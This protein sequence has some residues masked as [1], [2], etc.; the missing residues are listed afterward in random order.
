M[1][2]YPARTDSD[3]YF[4]MY[5]DEPE[6][7]VAFYTIAVKY[8]GLSVTA[9]FTLNSGEQRDDLVFT[10]QWAP[11][12]VRELIVFQDRTPLPR[13]ML[14]LNMYKE[15]LSTKPSAAEK[16]LKSWSIQR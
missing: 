6:F 1:E 12:S 10:P 9:E 5:V 3:G 13:A 8:Q 7:D 2:D 14:V 15:V 11:M 16:Q 4:V